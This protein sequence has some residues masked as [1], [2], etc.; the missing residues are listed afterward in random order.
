MTYQIISTTTPIITIRIIPKNMKPTTTGT[1][2]A[3]IH[4]Y[5]VIH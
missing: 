2:K 5:K 1:A 3:S 4:K